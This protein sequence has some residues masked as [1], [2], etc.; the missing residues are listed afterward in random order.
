MR[1][2]RLR[3]DQVMVP[4]SQM[5]GVTADTPVEAAKQQVFQDGHTR[6]PVYGAGPDDIEGILW[7]GALAEA[8]VETVGDL[9]RPALFLPGG[10]RVD[11]AIARLRE[12]RQKMAFVLDEF[13]GCAGLVTMEDLVEEIVGDIIS[14]G[15]GPP[16]IERLA[17]DR[18]VLDG[19]TPLHE[20]EYEL[21]VRLADEGHDTVGG[22]L[23]HSLG[24][25]PEP[26]DTVDVD[27]YQL[28]VTETE[29]RRVARVE[30][31][32]VGS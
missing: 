12:T 8:H 30:L 11:A 31:R 3:V 16:Q 4:R 15:D 32:E 2:H 23:L 28:V 1:L 29:D 22:F 7:V 14:E 24:R 9:A 19:S 10:L 17:D 27:S 5:V 21:G 13:G 26:G 25:V 6:M 20:V 18:V